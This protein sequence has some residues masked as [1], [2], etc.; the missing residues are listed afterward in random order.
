MNGIRDSIAAIKRRPII[1]VFLTV[2]VLLFCILEQ[3]NPFTKKIGTLGSILQ[4]DYLDNMVRLSNQIKAIATNASVLAIAV[5]VAI[6][7]IFAISC[8]IGVLFSGYY[9]NFYLSLMDRRAKKGDYVSGINKHFLKI[10]MLTAVVLILSAVFVVFL[11]FS[12]VPAVSIVKTFLQG[13]SQVFFPMLMVIILTCF[14]VYFS[15]VFFSMYSSYLYPSLIAFKKGG[16]LVSFRMV[17]GYCWY[18]MPRISGFLIL[19]ALVQVML[20]ALGYGLSSAGASIGVLLLNWI[21]K[22]LII[23]LFTYFIFSSFKAMKDDMV[24]DEVE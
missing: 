24:A 3:F 21:L 18:L 19:L 1:I 7:S 13:S 16:T 4:I 9:H 23:F 2:F 14:V 8:I 20:L 10:S 17:N 6:L 5:L 12:I 22:S 11:L 15:V